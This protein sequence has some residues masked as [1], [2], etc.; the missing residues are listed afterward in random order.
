MVEK[1][2]LLRRY[3]MDGNVDAWNDA[4]RGLSSQ[5]RQALNFSG[6]GLTSLNLDEIDLEYINLSGATIIG[7]SFDWAKLGHA[8]LNGCEIINSSFR[9]ADPTEASLNNAK[10]TRN[11]KETQNEFEGATFHGVKAQGVI[12]KG[13]CLKE[14]DVEGADFAGGTFIYVDFEGIRGNPSSLEGAKFNGCKSVPERFTPSKK[15]ESVEVNLSPEE[16]SSLLEKLKARLTA[17]QGVGR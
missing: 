5:Q 13:V 6:M 10:I 16:R 17:S 15:E 3:L 9:G 4:I 11:D 12:M 1:V 14:V 2:F 8:V 7:C